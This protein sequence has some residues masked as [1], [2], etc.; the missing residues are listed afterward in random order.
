[1]QKR[2]EEANIGR[3]EELL[4]TK[5]GRKRSIRKEHYL[6]YSCGKF[7]IQTAK[8]H[9]LTFEREVASLSSI[10]QINNLLYCR[11]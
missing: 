5:S 4:K 10:F 8:H 3:K 11:A 2:Q 9:G 6:F 7:K 1:M